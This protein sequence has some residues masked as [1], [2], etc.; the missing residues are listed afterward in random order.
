MDLPN[1]SQLPAQLPNLPSVSSL[2]TAHLI[3]LAAA[4]GWASGLRLYAVLF[5]T[6]IVGF[7]GWVPLPSGLSVLSNPVVL[8]A[9]G[10]MVF[11]EFFADKIP[12]L[13]SLWDMVHSV[14]R[15][16]AGAALAASVIGIHDNAAMAAVAAILG[17]TLAATSFGAKASTRAAIN[18]SPEPFSNIG[19]SLAEDAT[20][21]GGLWLAYN[22]P[23]PFIIAV[24]IFSIIAIWVISKMFRFIRRLMW[25]VVAIF[26][27]GADP[28]APKDLR[29][30]AIPEGMKPTL[31][32]S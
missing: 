22:Y 29:D 32:K 2:D 8:G 1:L 4:V 24:V 26:S 23:I 7:M 13:D 16:P 14:I 30:I 12:G 11:V 18:T 3:A 21:M 10:F 15:V 31:I 20:V 27:G 9:S 6:G 17:G 25:R 5:V 19:M 28:E